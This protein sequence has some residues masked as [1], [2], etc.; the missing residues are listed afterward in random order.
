MVARR[1]QIQ[2]VGGGGPVGLAAGWSGTVWGHGPAKKHI[3]RRGGKEIRWGFPSGSLTAKVEVCGVGVG[4]SVR[5]EGSEGAQTCAV[6]DAATPRRRGHQGQTEQ[7]AIRPCSGGGRHPFEAQVFGLPLQVFELALLHL[8]F[9]G[10][11]AGVFIGLLALYSS[12][13]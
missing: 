12:L 7:C 1:V 2:A 8:R 11:R 3:E 13:D 10:V 4:P 5:I 6:L 9:A